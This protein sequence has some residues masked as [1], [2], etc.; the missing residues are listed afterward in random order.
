VRIRRW[1]SET[2]EIIPLSSIDEVIADICKMI[3]E[4]AKEENEN[5]DKDKSD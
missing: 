2:N 4:G 1:N 3:E 5:I